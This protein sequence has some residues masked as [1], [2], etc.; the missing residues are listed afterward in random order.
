MA[1]PKMMPPKRQYTLGHLFVVVL[2]CSLL[3]TVYTLA[4]RAAR[5]NEFLNAAKSGD[6]ERLQQLVR[7]GVDV[8]Y[9]DGM[10]TT[11]LMMASS[12]GRID[13]VQFLLDNGASPNERAR[14]DGTPLIWAA[15]S[16]KMDVVKLLLNNGA[17]TTLTDLD[18]LTAADRAKKNGYIQI[19][20]YIAR[21]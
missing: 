10:H 14:F 20:N 2:V 8:H 21:Q 12:H 15:E 6:L 11:A 7:S 1:D 13:C 3:A 18:G 17:I 19:A 9:R 16:G 4:K 5:P